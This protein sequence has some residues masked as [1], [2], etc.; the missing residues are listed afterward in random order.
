MSEDSQDAK[1]ALHAFVE[2]LPNTQPSTSSADAPASASALDVLSF[3]THGHHYGVEG[4]FV[5]EILGHPPLTSLPG[6]PSFLDGVVLY[7]RHVV[8]VLN[9]TAWL[10]PDQQWP[11]E[12]ADRVIIVEHGALTVGIHAG[13]DVRLERWNTDTLQGDAGRLAANAR[14]YCT[15]IQEHD[16]HNT[17]L[18]DIT[19]IL[20]DAIARGT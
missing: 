8:G 1:P 2:A 7:R 6:S 15:G 11:H 17:L 13:Q 3:T 19:H 5:R 9:I 12:P 16:T 10:Y 4:T 18:L 20:R 14:T